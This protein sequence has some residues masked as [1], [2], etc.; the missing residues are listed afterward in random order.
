[1]GSLSSVNDVNVVQASI[2]VDIIADAY[3]QSCM[4]SSC[5]TSLHIGGVPHP[6]E[7]PSM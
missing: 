3:I 4:E 6:S 7:Q 2:L 1:M 5:T